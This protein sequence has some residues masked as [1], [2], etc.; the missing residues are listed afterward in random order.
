MLP[1]SKLT[2]LHTEASNGWGG[3]EIRILS[4]AE[5]F[6]DQGYR[7]ILANPQNGQLNAKARARGFEVFDIPFEKKTQLR[8]FFRV[9]KIIKD[10]KPDVIGTHSSVD[11][12]VGLL[13]ATLS[14]VACR[15]RYRHVSTPVHN[16][17]FNRFQYTSLCDHIITT[18]DCISEPLRKAFQLPVEKVRTIF[19]GIDVPTTLP[20]RNDSR[21]A[22]AQELHLPGS[23]RFVGMVAVL[24]SWKGHAYLIE[25]F[26]QI[27]D[28]FPAHHLILAGNGPQSH[29]QTQIDDCR[30]N[31]RIHLIG[32]RENPWMVFRALDVAVLS[33]FKNEGIPQTGLQAMFAE[34]PFLGTRVGGIPEII[35]HMKT[36][37]LV[38]PADSRSLSDGLQTVL[39]DA[40]LR[41]EIASQALNFAQTNATMDICGKAV[42]CL[43]KAGRKPVFAILV[44]GAIC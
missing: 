4:E 6:R 8:D 15:L 38:D 26:D 11:S 41:N 13:A 27:A 32:H 33:S 24:R 16:N 9:R 29:L 22:L 23:S 19:T 2:I 1:D 14:R 3:Q 28:Q 25:A 17:L 5:W 36:G 21:I 40:N 42:E 12:W 34:T 37:V 20:D 39:T 18:G 43:I 7:I 35:E 30:H 44:G 10:H 31:D